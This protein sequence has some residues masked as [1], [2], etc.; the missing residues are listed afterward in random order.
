[1][2]NKKGP[3]LAIKSPCP[4]LLSLPKATHLRG[5]RLMA[6]AQK[7]NFSRSYPVRIM[8]PHRGL[9]NWPTPRALN[10]LL[11]AG[12]VYGVPLSGPLVTKSA[13]PDQKACGE[14]FRRNWIEV[15]PALTSVS[16]GAPDKAQF[17]RA[18]F[19]TKDVIEYLH[20][21]VDKFFSKD[22]GLLLPSLVVEWVLSRLQER[23]SADVLELFLPIIYVIVE[24]IA[25]S[26][27]YAHIFID[28]V[29]RVIC[30]KP[31]LSR[32]ENV[33]VSSDLPEILTAAIHRAV[34]ML[35]A[36]GS[37]HGSA[38]FSY[39]RNLL[40]KYHDIGGVTKWEKNF[41]TTLG[42]DDSDEYLWKLSGRMSR[43]GVT[44]KELV[45]RRIED[46]VQYFHGKERKPFAAA[47][48]KNPSEIM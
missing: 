45:Q 3:S 24:R 31:Q 40:K 30:S 35:T 12:Q 10:R 4:P 14:D 16:S 17:A 5:S 25:L 46:A 21:L 8:R 44:M 9:G 11:L 26:Q 32:Y 15:R 48:T 13:F 18:D 39:A 1:M 23:V 19:W 22:E 36:N 28:I 33:L 38:A 41:R 20:L 47:V 2:S 42:V 29:V 37:A 43:F 27:T 6:E 7:G 34:T